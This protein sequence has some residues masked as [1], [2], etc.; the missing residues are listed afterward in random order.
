MSSSESNDDSPS[1]IIIQQQE[2]QQQQRPNESFLLKASIAGSVCAFVSALLNGVDVT[3]I[4]MQNQ[5]SS[6]IKYHG[7][8]SGMTYLF[9]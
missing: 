7:L 2:Q 1:I 9:R 6:N 3:K 5:A 4:R 8:L